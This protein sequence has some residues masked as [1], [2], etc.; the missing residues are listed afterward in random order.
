MAS[1]CA[2]NSSMVLPCAATHGF[3]STPYQAAPTSH[4]T[5]AAIT[6]ARW[7]TPAKLMTTLPRNNHSRRERPDGGPLDVLVLQLAGHGQRI[8]ALLHQPLA[9]QIRAA[10][11]AHQ[12]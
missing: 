4:A 6:I 8:F 9:R 3:A 2:W 12:R 5:I 7:F 11:V 10:G 1:R